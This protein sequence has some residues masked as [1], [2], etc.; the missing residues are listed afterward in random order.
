MRAHQ[1]M[2]RQVITIDPDASIVDAIR[3]MLTHRVGGLPVIDKGKL[4]GMVTESDFIRRAE[5]GTDQNRGRLLA[6]LATP[7]RTPVP[8]PR[9]A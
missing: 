5:L 1:I 9:T 7:L 6:F 3:T 8:R 2:S 4:V